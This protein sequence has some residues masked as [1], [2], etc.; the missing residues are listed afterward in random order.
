MVK[1]INIPE[2]KGIDFSAECISH[3]ALKAIMKFRIH[4]SVSAIRKTF[5]AGIF[6][7]SKVS[8]D[9]HL[10]EIIKLGNR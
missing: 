6:S 3:P 2:F 10:K 1:H 9:D 8:V 4:P 7:F 5:N